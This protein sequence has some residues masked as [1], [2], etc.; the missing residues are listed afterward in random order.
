MCRKK[1]SGKVNL[2]LAVSENVAYEDV[3]LKDD[4]EGDY[5]NAAEIV[6]KPFEQWSQNDDA[7]YSTILCTTTTKPPV[8]EYT[9]K[10]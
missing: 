5:E 3:T 4:T 10:D 8:S 9:G 6:L 1:S 7:V 2:K